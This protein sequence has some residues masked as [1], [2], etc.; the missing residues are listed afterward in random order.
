MEESPF[1]CSIAEQA[2]AYGKDIPNGS[3]VHRMYA[4][5]APYSVNDDHLDTPSL[6]RGRADALDHV[7]LGD[8][9]GDGSLRFCLWDDSHRVF[10]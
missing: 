6:G 8:G 4:A 7:P 3:F 9:L 10:R 2:L 5:H 1:N